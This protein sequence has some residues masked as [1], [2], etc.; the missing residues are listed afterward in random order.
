[1]MFT[2]PFNFVAFLAC[3]ISFLLIAP[4]A[5]A[6]QNILVDYNF[7]TSSAKSIYGLQDINA[8]RVCIQ[9]DCK[10]AWPTGGANFSTLASIDNYIVVTVN[11]NGTYANLSFNLTTA[12][13][14]YALL[15]FA[16]GLYNNLSAQQSMTANLSANDTTLRA[17]ID[18]VNSTAVAK[19]GT[20]TASCGTGFA[21]MNVTTTTGAPTS[22]CV[23]VGTGNGSVTS[24]AAS[25]TG[26]GFTVSGTPVTTTGTLAF[27]ITTA[28]ATVSG[29]LN[30]TD[31]VSFNASR[32]A[33]VSSVAAAVTGTT[34]FSV[35]GSPITSTGTITLTFQNATAGQDGILRSTD[36]TT[37]SNKLDSSAQLANNSSSDIS[38]TGTYNQLNAQISAGVVGANELSSLGTAGTAGNASHIGVT[39]YDADGRES[40]WSNVAVNIPGN[41]INDWPGACPTGTRMSAINASGALTI[42]CDPTLTGLAT[43]SGVSGAVNA[44]GTINLTVTAGNASSTGIANYIPRFDTVTTTL[45]PSA[46]YDDTLGNIGLGRI[47]PLQKFHLNGTMRIDNATGSGVFFANATNGRVGIGTVTPSTVLHIV[48]GAGTPTL[49]MDSGDTATYTMQFNNNTGAPLLTFELNPSGNNATSIRFFRTTSTTGTAAFYIFTANNTGTVN[50]QLAGNGNSFV[51]AL[52]GNFGVQDQ[53]P[54]ELFVVGNGDLFRVNS[55]GHARGIAGTVGAPAYTFTG[56]DNTGIYNPG[57]NRLGMVAAGEEVGEFNSNGLNLTTDGDAFSLSST[58]GLAAGA[59]CAGFATLVSGAATVNTTCVQTT[60]GIIL[61]AMSAGGTVGNKYVSGISNGVHFNITSTNVLDTSQVYWEI[62]HTY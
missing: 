4:A 35:S 21:A 25:A 38:I 49:R 61:S 9:G 8:S 46:L 22:Q 12:D 20:G 15:T 33:N 26:Q 29:V 34:A 54:S 39:T 5:H 44:N 47:S 7:N 2:K 19:A 18:S 53:S 6:A 17:A 31:W 51:S 60:D 57:A 13:A 50:H 32:A 55:S 36:F 28:N 24:V 14:R 37:F 43:L 42:Y 10:S 45:E 23:A 27:T 1:M 40:S 62:R 11:S 3:V 30:N 41:A 52:L 48:D 58:S 16:Q 59:S 56:D